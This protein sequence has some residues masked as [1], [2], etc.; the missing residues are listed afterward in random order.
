VYPLKSRITTKT[1]TVFKQTELKTK[2][3]YTNSVEGRKTITEPKTLI[4]GKKYHQ[5]QY[6]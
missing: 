5:S 4:C 6:I 2:Q 1:S 3:K